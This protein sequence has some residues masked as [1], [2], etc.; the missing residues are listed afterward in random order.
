MQGSSGF[1]TGPARELRPPRGRRGRDR[2][3]RAGPDPGPERVGAP[4][5]ALPPFERSHA[6]DR[7][8]AKPAL[9]E[10]AVQLGLPA[11]G[12]L[13]VQVSQDLGGRQARVLVVAHSLQ[14]LAV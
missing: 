11:L 10:V 7:G 12:Q 8:P 4:E 6:L 9:V 13:A 1:H 14:P 5:E 2:R 3:R